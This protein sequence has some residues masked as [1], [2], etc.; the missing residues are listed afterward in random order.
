M[1]NC[2]REGERSFSG[3]ADQKCSTHIKEAIM[4]WI[5]LALW[6]SEGKRRLGGRIYVCSSP[7]SVGEQKDKEEIIVRA[8]TDAREEI[9]RRSFQKKN[10]YI[11]S[12]W[13]NSCIS[14]LAAASVCDYNHIRM[15]QSSTGYSACGP[16]HNV[17]PSIRHINLLPLI[18]PFIQS[19]NK[20]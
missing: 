1:G 14:V 8:K 11:S 13:L 9:K 19:N 20:E 5:I 12:P 7:W 10:P 6:R 4:W 18:C 16:Y 2:E 17:Y 3:P 15:T